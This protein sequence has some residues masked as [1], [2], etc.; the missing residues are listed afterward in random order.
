MMFPKDFNV[1]ASRVSI[2]AWARVDATVH[3][4]AIPRI[5]S[6]LGFLLLYH[7]KPN[8]FVYFLGGKRRKKDQKVEYT[9]CITVRIPDVY[10]VFKSPP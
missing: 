10:K 6:P 4:P 2:G 8:E 5:A 3:A 9:P 7:F 1:V